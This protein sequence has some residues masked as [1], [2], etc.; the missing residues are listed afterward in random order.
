MGC[1]PAISLQ[2][3]AIGPAR[4]TGA[5]LVTP[6]VNIGAI[7]KHLEQTPGRNQPMR[8]RQCHRPA[9]AGWHGSP[10]LIV[11]GNG[12]LMPLNVRARAELRRKH[13]GLSA[14][15]LAQPLRPSTLVAMP[16]TP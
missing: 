8:Q 6:A 14:P 15:Q 5:A 16:G 3:G 12:V 4:G 13:I 9:G 2:R 10:Q 1:A 7:N 11:P